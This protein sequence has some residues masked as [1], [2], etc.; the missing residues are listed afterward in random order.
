MLVAIKHVVDDNCI[1]QQD[2]VLDH[3]EFNC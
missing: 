1:F 3:L 2:S